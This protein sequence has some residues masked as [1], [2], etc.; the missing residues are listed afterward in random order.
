MPTA[1]DSPGVLSHKL[2][3]I[4]AG[5]YTSTFSGAADIFKPDTSQ[6]YRT[7]PLPKSCY[8]ISLV[9]IGR[10]HWLTSQPSTL[11]LS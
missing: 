1:R 8:D 6:R 3:L 5:G 9:A 11:C 4:V 7:D 10:I 2:A